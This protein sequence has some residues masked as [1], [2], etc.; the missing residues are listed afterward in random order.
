[1]YVAAIVKYY[2]SITSTEC[3]T[4]YIWTSYIKLAQS[5]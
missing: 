4:I 3:I 5:V 2:I 1:M